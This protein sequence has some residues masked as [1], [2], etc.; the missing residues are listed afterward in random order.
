M[1]N[2]DYAAIPA[3]EARNGAR[4]NDY[5]KYRG[6]ANRDQA[7]LNGSNPGVFNP[8]QFTWASNTLQHFNNALVAA[9]A[10]GDPNAISVAQQNLNN[11]TQQNHAIFTTERQLRTK[12]ANNQ[13]KMNRAL[14]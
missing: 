3:G 5:N 6:K 7:I 1:A 12:L 10:T 11:F 13:A 2:Q 14:G 4:Q 8:A 9:Q